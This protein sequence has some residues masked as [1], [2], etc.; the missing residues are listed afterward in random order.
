MPTVWLFLQNY[1]FDATSDEFSYNVFSKI[2]YLQTFSCNMDKQPHEPLFGVFE[3]SYTM[4]MILNIFCKTLAFLDDLRKTDC[5]VCNKSFSTLRRLASHL[6][7]VH[8]YSY[9]D[10]REVTG[11]PV[12][13]KR[14]DF[15]QKTIKCIICSNMHLRLF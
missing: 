7:T 2:T 14:K 8:K 12:Y 10:A 3:S 9:E 5:D 15:K 6:Q 11:Y 4:E 1:K 13:Q